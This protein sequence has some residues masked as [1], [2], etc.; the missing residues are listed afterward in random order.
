[1]PAFFGQVGGG[2]DGLVGDEL[3]GEV[4]EA[5]RL[6][7]GIGDAQFVEGV[8]EAQDAEPYRT[9]AQVGSPGL[10][11]AVVV[12]VDDVVEHAHGGAHGLGQA[13]RV[14]PP[15]AHVGG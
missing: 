15:F 10:G 6:F 3:H 9:V 4:G 13:V 12:V 14:Q 7:A 11:Y 5:D 1:M 2:L 8:L